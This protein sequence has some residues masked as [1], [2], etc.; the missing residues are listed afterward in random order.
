MTAQALLLLR[1]R[2]AEVPADVLATAGKRLLAALDRGAVR[3]ASPA[4]AALLLEVLEAEGPTTSA[5]AHLERQLSGG[6]PAL[7]PAAHGLAR[8]F[9]SKAAPL[10]G[11]LWK[12]LANQRTPI[13]ERLE[14]LATLARIEA[15]PDGKRWQALLADP[16]PEVRT[17][18]VRWWRSFKGQPDLVAALVARAPALVADGPQLRDDLASVL[19]QL[20]V[21]PAVGKKLGLGRPEEDRDA[22]A[23]RT[24]QALARLPK[25]EQR[26]RALAGRMVF[27]RSACV[28]CHTTVDR[29]TP[30]APSLRGVARGQKPD[31]L[32]E[33]V[34][35]PSKVIKTGFETE[36]V[37]TKAGK[38]LTG[39]VKD[40]GKVLRILDA[41][42]EVRLR[43]SDVE[44]REV[45][46]V[47][48][49]PEGQE[50]QLSRN[51]FL[52][53]IVYLSSLR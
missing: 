53:L 47:S 31:Y 19:A 10:A 14:L 49:M 12:R 21:A 50:K 32:V 46:K 3:I 45:Q 23:R 41:D 28:K 33:S 24:L 20:E 27:E 18:A 42:G 43:K 1:A 51:E 13:E 30:R 52:D 40:D 35:Y 22:L 25:N 8:R 15:R 44:T 2:S 16:R 6:P 37:T 5:L 39:L 29:D 36:R 9:G 48:L 34:L 7:R 17:E 4:E 11:P 26:S 38:V